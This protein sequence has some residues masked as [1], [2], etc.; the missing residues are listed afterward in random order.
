MKK[1]LKA[2]LNILKADSFM[3]ATEKDGHLLID[4]TMTRTQLVVMNRAVSRKL[5]ETT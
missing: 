5:I 3:I 4:S 1:K 2:I